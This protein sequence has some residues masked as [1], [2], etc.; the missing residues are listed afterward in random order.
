MKYSTQHREAD[1]P[2]I[3]DRSKGAIYLDV[4]VVR[5]P[6][7]PARVPQPNLSS[8]V[9]SGGTGRRGFES[10][11]QEQPGTEMPARKLVKRNVGYDCFCDSF[12]LFL[13]F[14]FAFRLLPPLLAVRSHSPNIS[15]PTLDPSKPTRRYGTKT[16]KARLS[17][18]SESS[19]DADAPSTNGS[20]D[21]EQKDV[22]DG[23]YGIPQTR[24]LKLVK[25]PGRY[26]SYSTFPSRG[27]AKADLCL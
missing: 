6:K 13:L 12:L 3:P 23:A 15:N 21:A 7:P 19:S 4:E 17:S 5:S 27:S 22:E 26:V 8:G 11:D 14:P 25:R 1:H 2:C 18:S 9:D 16:K 20:G 10:R 24:G